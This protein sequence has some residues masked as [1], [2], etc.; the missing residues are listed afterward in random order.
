MPANRDIRAALAYHNVKQWQL[1]DR[2]GFSQENLS[3]TLRKELDPK[4]KAKYTQL[5]E[6]I[7]KEEGHD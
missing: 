4:R 6:E 5:I 3:K 7:A 2:L 1:A